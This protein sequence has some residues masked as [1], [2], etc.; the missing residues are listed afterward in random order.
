[1]AFAVAGWPAADRGFVGTSEGLSQA[2]AVHPVAESV[3]GV[4][5]PAADTGPAV[6]VAV[7]AAALGLE[8]E[9]S[10]RLAW[11]LLY[12]RMQHQPQET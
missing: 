1:M 6:L 9:D 8:V 4:R 7:P 2:F 10:T 5:S 11:G 12:S 3:V